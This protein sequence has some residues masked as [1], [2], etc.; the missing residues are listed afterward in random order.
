MIRIDDAFLEQVG[1]GDVAPPDRPSLL[2]AILA[3]LELRV[4][5]RLT[6]GLSQDQLDEFNAIHSD[7]AAARG[8]LDHHQPEIS[9]RISSDADA[10]LRKAASGLWLDTHRPDHRSDV[11][12]VLEAI[13]FELR[14]NAKRLVQAIAEQDSARAGSGD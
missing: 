6:T 5:E 10:E 11:R 3:E 1:L 8:W 7:V 2:Q 14:S 4:G 13:R 12:V 9:A